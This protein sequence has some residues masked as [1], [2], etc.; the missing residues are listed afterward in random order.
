[1]TA[2]EEYRSA[3]RKWEQVKVSGAYSRALEKSWDTIIANRAIDAVEE[4]E[5]KLSA[6]LGAVDFWQ[7]AEDEVQEHIAV[8]RERLVI[9]IATDKEAGTSAL[10]PVAEVLRVIGEELD[11]V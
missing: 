4:L 1:M 8:L 2:I 7:T 9:R 11:R 6:A 3:V 10:W 5:C